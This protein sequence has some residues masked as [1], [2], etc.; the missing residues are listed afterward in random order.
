MQ[1]I[2][3]GVREREKEKKFPY[4]RDLVRKGKLFERL[5]RI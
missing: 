4:Q 5:R 2:G 3:A 1:G